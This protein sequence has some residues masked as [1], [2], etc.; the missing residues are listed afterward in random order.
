MRHPGVL[1]ALMA[2]LAVLLASCGPPRGADVPSDMATASERP[3]T[4]DDLRRGAAPTSPAP[5]TTRGMPPVPTPTL[6]LRMI[7]PCGERDHPVPDHN[8][9]A[10]PQ[11]TYDDPHAELRRR[12]FHRT[13]DYACD[14]SAHGCAGD[15]TRGRG[16]DGPHGHCPAPAFRDHARIDG[17]AITV[18]YGEPN[19]E[20]DRYDWPYPS[21]PLYVRW[22]HERY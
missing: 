16:Y 22:W 8:P 9:P 6:S 18:Q 19:P 17:D 12:G 2:G 21:W 15:Y 3:A 11:G 4:P 5:E 13:A 1:L 10:E 14:A 7:R 20:V